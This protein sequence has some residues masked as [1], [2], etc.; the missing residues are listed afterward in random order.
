VLL[1]YAYPVCKTDRLVREALDR[2]LPVSVLDHPANRH[3]LD[4]GASMWT[5][6]DDNS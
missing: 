4:L 2:G 6:G 1:L 5:V 3:W